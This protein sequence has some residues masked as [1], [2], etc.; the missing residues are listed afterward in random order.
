MEKKSKI[1]L[2]TVIKIPEGKLEEFKQWAIQVIKLVREKDTGTLKYD[3][4]FNSDQTECEVREEFASQKAM[5]EHAING[6]EMVLSS[7]SD[8]SID[9]V[10]VFGEP[11]PLLLEISKTK[12]SNFPPFE[13]YTFFMRLDE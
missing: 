1:Q 8:F 3:W 9:H 6:Q 4:F 13:L 12:E 11:P 7:R 10:K 2:N 5:I